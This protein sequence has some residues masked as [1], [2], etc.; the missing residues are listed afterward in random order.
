MST[1]PFCLL[2]NLKKGKQE[3]KKNTEQISVGHQ[4]K[5]HLQK[6][7][8]KRH[9]IILGRKKFNCYWVFSE[10]LKYYFTKR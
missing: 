7:D 8:G 6:D 5:F 9:I 1:E 2:G 3:N 10:K 4:V